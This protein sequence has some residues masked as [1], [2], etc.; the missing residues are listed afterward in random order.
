MS[1][2]TA[3]ERDIPNDPFSKDVRIDQDVEFKH[4]HPHFPT[5]D[6]VNNCLH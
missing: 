1:Q 3:Y 6:D 5:N 4:I 2:Q